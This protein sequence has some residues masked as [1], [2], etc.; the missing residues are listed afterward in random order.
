MI[1]RTNDL[2]A[3]KKRYQTYA[4]SRNELRTKRFFR[5]KNIQK[6]SIEKTK[7]NKNNFYLKNIMSN[8]GISG[9]LKTVHMMILFHA[10]S[11]EIQQHLP[12]LIDDQIKPS[13]KKKI[14]S[15][16]S[17]AFFNVYLCYYLPINKISSVVMFANIATYVVATGANRQLNDL[18][19]EY[20]ENFNLD[21]IK[22]QN[23]VDK[24]RTTN[25][26]TDMLGVNDGSFAALKLLN[27]INVVVIIADK[28]Y[29]KK[30]SGIENLLL[31]FFMFKISFS[32]VKTFRLTSN[33]S[34]Y[35]FS[36]LMN[37]IFSFELDLLPIMLILGLI[38]I[39]FQRS[40]IREK[41]TN[42][43]GFV[44]AF[45][46]IKFM[47]DMLE[48]S[49]VKNNIKIVNIVFLNDFLGTVCINNFAIIFL[50]IETDKNNLILKNLIGKNKIK[51]NEK[52][53]VIIDFFKKFAL[54]Y[55]TC[56]FIEYNRNHLLHASQQHRQFVFVVLDFAIK[57]SFNFVFLTMHV[58]S[59]QSDLNQFL[60]VKQKI[61]KAVTFIAEKTNLQILLDQKKLQIIKTLLFLKI[62]LDT[63]EF[64]SLTKNIKTAKKQILYTK[65]YYEN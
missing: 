44:Y 62:C 30:L 29:D 42:I 48:D 50:L 35:N 4:I 5:T 11:C 22:L 58:Y 45:L 14:Y 55:I 25:F 47:S 49:I 10:I 19:V 2:F 20:M 52:I 17:K 18:I 36:N 54:M 9:L 12:N 8:F 38:N 21:Q 7:Q 13:F 43:R 28:F 57:L 32:I 34:D 41:F 59:L 16:L 40:S 53:N 46:K 6:K 51:L 65:F 27:Y 31:I 15:F 60:F 24:L 39:V 23:L 56:F 26:F 33:D 3:A 61:A 63:A 37:L 1:E 64:I